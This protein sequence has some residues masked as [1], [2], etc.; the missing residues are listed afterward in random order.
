MNTKNLKN[1]VNDETGLNVSTIFM[2]Y[3]MCLRFKFNFESIYNKVTLTIT[4]FKVFA[5]VQERLKYTSHKWE[6]IF[7][8]SYFRIS[9]FYF[10]TRDIVSIISHHY[11]K[12]GRSIFY[13]HIREGSWAEETVN[14][15]GHVTQNL[16]SKTHYSNQDKTLY[17]IWEDNSNSTVF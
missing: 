5:R 11:S 8:S 2:F 17:Y 7:P 4:K 14:W 9:L 3:V 1:V 10:F 16:E 12:P 13:S 15:S 6:W